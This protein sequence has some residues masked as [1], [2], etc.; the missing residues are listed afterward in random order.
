MFDQIFTGD[1]V[2][3][4]KFTKEE[5]PI[6]RSPYNGTN[7]MDV[8][9]TWV[10]DNENLITVS[11]EGSGDDSAAVLRYGAHT[12]YDAV[13]SRIDMKGKTRAFNAV[14]FKLKATA[15]HKVFVKLGAAE[16]KIGEGDIPLPDG[17]THEYWFILPEA[18]T[19]PAE[20]IVMPGCADSAT[21][22]GEVSIYNM[23]LTSVSTLDASN[24]VAAPVFF[25][26]D[27]PDANGVQKFSAA[28]AVDGKVTANVT[29]TVDNGWVPL[30]MYVDLGT[31]KY[32]NF[33]FTMKGK[34]GGF[35]IVAVGMG[36]N[37]D[38]TKIEYKFEGG[39]LLDGTDQASSAA[40]VKPAD[41]DA[42]NAFT[43]VVR[44]VIYYDWDVNSGTDTFEISA[45]TMIPLA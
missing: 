12:G 19:N 31:A 6:S 14:R 37:Y 32:K 40:A 45:L 3:G 16:Y 10:A 20:V 11:Y 4:V 28:T 15:G 30:T 18:V 23:F 9:R 44:V 38:Q 36:T 27:P 5:L 43:G 42:A 29:H 39:V 25:N 26:G 34:N 22:A 21:T 7:E 2:L 1:I 8:N 17:E 33:S 41:K 35:A 24:K 13:K